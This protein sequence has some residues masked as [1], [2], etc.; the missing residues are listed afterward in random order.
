MTWKVLQLDEALHGNDGSWICT[1]QERSSAKLSLQWGCMRWILK[2]YL[3]FPMKHSTEPFWSLG[4]LVNFNWISD[5]HTHGRPERH[6]H[7][8]WIHFHIGCS[9]ADTEVAKTGH[10]YSAF[11]VDET[12]ANVQQVN[13]PGLPLPQNSPRDSALFVGHYFKTWL[14][15]YGGKMHLFMEKFMHAVSIRALRCAY[16]EAEGVGF[17]GQCSAR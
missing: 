13:V 15:T 10:A 6:L 7:F 11:L 2:K 16:W 5:I 8:R 9:A 12:K 14:S 3:V 17:S 4:I 1:V